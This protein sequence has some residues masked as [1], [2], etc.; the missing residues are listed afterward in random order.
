MPSVPGTF[1][2]GKLTVQCHAVHFLLCE[3]LSDCISQE[4]NWLFHLDDQICGYT[5][6]FYSFCMYMCAYVVYL[7][8]YVCAH[9]Y[10]GPRG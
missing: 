2:F 7:C 3:F 4:I 6:P 1:C 8:V 5:I 10:I 9:V